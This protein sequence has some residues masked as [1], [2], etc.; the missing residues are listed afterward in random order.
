MPYAEIDVH[1]TPA[2]YK[3]GCK[4]DAMCDG[5]APWSCKRAYERYR[6][7]YAFHQRIDQGLTPSEIHELEQADAERLAQEERAWLEREGMKA[8]KPAKEQKPKTTRKGSRLQLVDPTSGYGTATI[9]AARSRIASAP[10]PDHPAAALAASTP[11]KEHPMPV[12][13]KPA[14]AEFAWQ[15]PPA[16]ALDKTRGRRGGYAWHIQQMKAKPKVWACLGRH[17]SGAETRWRTGKVSGTQPRQFEAVLDDRPE[18]VD[19][20]G[21]G[22]LYV[23]YVGQVTA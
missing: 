16:A 3:A 9:T 4:T 7:D 10:T 19:A 13:P 17:K 2:G 23:R 8:P 14:D 1:G 5:S 12:P 22:L 6:G 20:S 18:V 11:T 15:A 21:K